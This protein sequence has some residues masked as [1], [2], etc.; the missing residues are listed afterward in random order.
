MMN[1]RERI[2]VD[3]TVL[4]GKPVI[5]GTRLSVELILDRLADGWTAQ[6]VLQAYPRIRR[7]SS[8]TRPSSRRIQFD[9]EVQATILAEGQALLSAKATRKVHAKKAESLDPVMASFLMFL[10]DRCGSIPIGSGR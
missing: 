3:P 5:R 4:A 9:G 10:E 2:A 8:S 6:D 7:V 1:W